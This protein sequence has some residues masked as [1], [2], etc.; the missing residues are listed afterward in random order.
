[1]K[2]LLPILLFITTFSFYAQDCYGLKEGVFEMK[3][4]YGTTI[5]ERQGNW[6]LEKSIEYGV[7][8]LNKIE[9]I[10]DCKYSVS[11]YKVIDKGNLPDLGSSNVAVT[12]ILKVEGSI[13]YFKTTLTD[14]G[15]VLEDKF[16]KTQ[17]LVSKEF[18]EI[19]AKENILKE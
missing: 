19:L 3:N 7:V 15:F 2:F 11:L 13:F 16:V 18:E 12:E 8:Y 9:K 1:M 6:Q 10:N 14:T 4:D 5:I 17:D